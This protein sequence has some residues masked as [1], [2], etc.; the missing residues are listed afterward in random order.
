MEKKYWIGRKRAAMT[1]ANDA[2]S[3]EAR[4]I[5]FDLA[6]RYSIKAAQC[7]PSAAPVA[8][9]RR[10]TLHLRQPLSPPRSSFYVSG[11]RPGS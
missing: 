4:L 3:A 7:I 9:T 11:E 10:A 5:H 2:S 1:M 8:T 6:G